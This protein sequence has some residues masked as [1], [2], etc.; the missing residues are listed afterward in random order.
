MTGSGLA[1]EKDPGDEQAN[2]SL[3]PCSVPQA[4]TT[5]GETEAGSLAERVIRTAATA[6]TSGVGKPR[7]H[8]GGWRVSGQAG[9][10]PHAPAGVATGLTG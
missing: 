3:H 6:L 1:Q 9:N 4:R 10:A 5:A 8:E 7:K 2:L